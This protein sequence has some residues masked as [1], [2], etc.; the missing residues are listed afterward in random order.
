MAQSQVGVVNLALFHIEQK[1]I[2]SIDENTPMARD[3]KAVWDY[4]RDEVLE[5][6]EWNFAKTEVELT[7]DTWTSTGIWEYRYAKPSSCLR[8]CRE[9]G[10][11]DEAGNEIAYEEIGDYI[12]TD[13]DNTDADLYLTYITIITDVTKWSSIFCQT[14]AY[15]LAAALSKRLKSGDE[16]DMLNKYELT[17]NQAIALNQSR[18]YIENDKGS[19]KWLEAGR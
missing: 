14:V 9:K 18:V 1:S 12:Y 10:L 4:I 17:L 5:R 15:R 13:F 8:I 3:A 2:S 7:Q 11:R 16:N 19:N 6:F